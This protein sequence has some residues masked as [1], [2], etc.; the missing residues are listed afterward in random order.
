MNYDKDLVVILAPCLGG[1][2]VTLEAMVR[3]VEGINITQ[4]QVN[5]GRYEPSLPIE[6]LYS[7][8]TQPNWLVLA[9]LQSALRVDWSASGGDWQSVKT[10]YVS[11]PADLGVEQLRVV[12]RNYRWVRADATSVQSL[13]DFDE[14]KLFV[15]ASDEAA[16]T[17]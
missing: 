8:S 11:I 7:K 9:P 3:V 4:R 1:C 16:G 13:M 15:S 14:I 17:P 12:L 2:R 5:E 6:V 10:P